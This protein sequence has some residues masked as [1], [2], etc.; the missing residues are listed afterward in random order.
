MK[1]IKEIDQ[2]VMERE[3]VR[4][5]WNEGRYE[6]VQELTSRIFYDMAKNESVSLAMQVNLA[7]HILIRMARGTLISRI[8]RKI[9]W[10]EAQ[11]SIKEFGSMQ[12]MCERTWNDEFFK[13]KG[14]YTIADIA[15]S[16][17]RCLGMTDKELSDEFKQHTR[18]IIEVYKSK[19]TANQRLIIIKSN[20]SKEMTVLEGN[21]RAVAFYMRYLLGSRPLP[22]QFILGQSPNMSIYPWY[23]YKNHFKNTL[24]QINN[25]KKNS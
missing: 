6:H 22:K 20:Q 8:P 4:S 5:E 13:Y 15:K 14:L 11:L 1:I 25:G 16:C 9:K 21:H 23:N 3:W 24:K 12:I 7:V 19:R 17:I 18:K 2:W 10:Y